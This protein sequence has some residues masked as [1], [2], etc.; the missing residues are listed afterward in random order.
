[1]E[2]ISIIIPAYN[3]AKRIKQTVQEI[4]SFL[5]EQKMNA[6]VLVID[7]G[8]KDNTA[9]IARQ[10]K[11]PRLLVLAY[12]PNQGKGFA[13]RTGVKNAT[14]D[15][16]VFIDADHSI[17]I[18]HM[19]EFLPELKEYDIII[20]SKALKS[21]E[22]VKSQKKHREFLGRCFNFLVRI[23]TGIKFRDTQCGFKLFKKEPA[24]R[25]FSKMKV[26]R[27]SF[28]VEALYLAKKFNYRVK[29]MPIILT[30]RETS[31]VSIV[32][33]SISMLKDV[34]MIRIRDFSGKYR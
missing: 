7:D 31:R 16:L 24:K 11:D 17:S 34:I 22:K 8:S 33:D 25:I 23:I 13:I 3:E 1:M 19:I 12:R 9:K 32:F 30:E 28:D 21:T 10:I 4:L 15:I 29:E 6:E 20:G 5:K 18:E 26:R 27:F 2:K 14:G